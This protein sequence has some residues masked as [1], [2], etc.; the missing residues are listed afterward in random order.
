MVS[1]TLNALIYFAAFIIIAAIVIG[2]LDYTLIG[3]LS[4]A[5]RLRRIYLIANERL[6]IVAV[7][8]DGTL[9]YGV[10]SITE[11]T[12]KIVKAEVIFDDGTTQELTPL[13]G[14]TLN[15]GDVVTGKT[16][17]PKRPVGVYVVTE[18]GAVFTASIIDL[19]ATRE[20]ITLVGLAPA[21]AYLELPQSFSGRT[22]SK[23]F[24]TVTFEPYVFAYLTAKDLNSSASA[25]ATVMFPLTN[26]YE[27]NDTES[28]A[29]ISDNAVIIGTATVGAKYED[30]S[31]KVGMNFSIV[32]RAGEG[33][34]VTGAVGI[35]WIT[36]FSTTTYVNAEYNV[37]GREVAVEPDKYIADKIIITEAP[38]TLDPKTLIPFLE[39][40]E[41]SE[42]VTPP[43]SGHVGIVLA[44]VFKIYDPD[45][46][47]ISSTR[48][49]IGVG[50]ET[51]YTFIA[52]PER[53]VLG[54]NVVTISGVNVT[55]S[56]SYSWIIE[57]GLSV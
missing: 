10:R 15:P 13:I 44:K 28:V 1:I 34:L 19:G 37:W 3:V 18:R 53:N 33:L 46:T 23:A 35:I 56:A 29:L 22:A 57:S 24:A 30:G 40:W 7:R 27:G 17:L 25:V 4:D 52:F 26:I 31:V 49:T 5:Y 47:T 16:G 55:V 51:I 48:E 6:R 14:K 45:A 9:W 39:R 8:D 50:S 54:N 43:Y 38:A 36:T 11:A 32:N 12:V 20:R 21:I 41:S 42:P 2:V